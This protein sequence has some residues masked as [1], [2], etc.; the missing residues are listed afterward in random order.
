MH[1][2][3]AR[4][5]SVDRP[6]GDAADEVATLFTALLPGPKRAPDD[7][8]PALVCDTVLVRAGKLW[9]WIQTAPNGQVT[10]RV[11]VSADAVHAA[12]RQQGARDGGALAA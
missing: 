3:A 1:A 10:E 9:K 2:A 4:R 5:A 7:R 6:P 8:L 11:H 12:Y